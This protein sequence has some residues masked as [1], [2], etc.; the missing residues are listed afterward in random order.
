[1]NKLTNWALRSLALWVLAKALERAN[2][3]LRRRQR[4]RKLRAQAQHAAA[5][6]RTLPST[7][8]NLLPH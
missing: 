2:S 8:A 3:G 6:P 4:D 7:Q 5:L 1:M